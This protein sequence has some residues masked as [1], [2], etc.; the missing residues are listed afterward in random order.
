[1]TKAID[2]RRLRLVLLGAS[3]VMVIVSIAV[4]VA[5]GAGGGDDGPPQNKA[6]GLVPRETLLYVHVST[7]GDRDAVGEALDTFNTFPGDVAR[8]G[9]PRPAE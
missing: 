8:P 5:R 3:V 4:L 7:D 6:A 9:S 2:D 1:M